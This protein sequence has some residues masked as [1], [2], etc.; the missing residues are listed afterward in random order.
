[1]TGAALPPL[2]LNAWL[3][4]DALMRVW[5]AGGGRVLEVGCGQGALGTRLALRYD[6]LGLEPDPVSA[7]TARRRLQRLGRGTV[8]QGDIAVLDPA[9]R[10]DLICAFEV[11][12]HLAD[13][14]DALERWIHHLA[15]GGTLLLSTPA[16]PHRFGPA[17][18]AVG[19]VRRYEP[20]RLVALLA[21]LDL[22]EVRVIRY[23]GPLGY[24]L[25]T[26]RHALARRVLARAGGPGGPGG[27]APER[28]AGSG[29]WHQPPALLGVAT[30][31][32]SLPFRLLQRRL[33]G[34]G[35]GLLA[36]ARRPAGRAVARTG[37]VRL[38]VRPG[39]HDEV[40]EQPEGRDDQPCHQQQ[41]GVDRDPHRVGDQVVPGLDHTDS[42]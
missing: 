1:M 14:R 27:S 25:E 2:T 9:D 3:R 20:A 40:G 15:P 42:Q 32:G 4:Y 21:D 18:E 11:I 19:H 37:P 34:R 28:T 12:E 17:D 26:V 16:D 39:A 7:G 5:P 24:A 13:D 31:A 29:R 36:T 35:T 33:P 22:V 6:Y 8:R 41:D 23:G 38:A 30:Q 10:F